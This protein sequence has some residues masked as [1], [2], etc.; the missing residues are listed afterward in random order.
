MP[1]LI[2]AVKRGADYLAARGVEGA[3]GDA[4]RLLADALG[5]DRMTLYMDHDRPLCEDERERVRMLLRRRGKREPLQYILGTQ[6]FREL[7]LSVTP[8]VLVPRAETE[9]VVD[10]ALAEWD[11]IAKTAE[12]P[13]ALDLGTGSGAIALSLAAER[14]DATVCAVELSPAALLVARDNARRLGLDTR[15][16]FFE[17]DLLGPVAGEGVFHL[18]V[19]NPP[20]LTPEEWRDAPPEVRD[21]EPRQALVGGEDGLAVYRRLFAGVTPCLAPGGAVVVE[22]GH[23]QGAAVV[24]IAGD[25]GFDVTLTRDLGGR[26]RVVTARAA[27]SV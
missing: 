18:I 19:S 10:V 5:V 1:T 15:V 7:V 6:P 2:E 26:E 9:E 27:G 17:G 14:P 20:Y 4:E 16:R 3:R 25:A 13:R 23:T 8:E 24:D 21:Y 22:V 12:H 11:R